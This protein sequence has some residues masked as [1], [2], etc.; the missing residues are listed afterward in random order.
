MTTGQ[1]SQG[2]ASCVE[3][4]TSFFS[5]LAYPKI[6]CSLQ[7]N[8]YES[9]FPSSFPLLAWCCSC[10]GH[11]LCSLVRFFEKCLWMISCYTC[12]SDCWFCCLLP[13]G[14]WHDGRPGLRPPVIPANHQPQYISALFQH[15]RTV[16]ASVVILDKIL[17]RLIIIII[18]ISF[19]YQK[20]K[21]KEPLI[22]WDNIFF[23]NWNHVSDLEISVF[24]FTFQAK[25]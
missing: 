24:S 7:S 17:L 14:L 5:Q 9:L 23:K 4:L 16:A 2:G 20:Y 11:S 25:K 10:F 18:H 3:E 19:H 1:T 22:T 21:S 12:T 13:A 15:Q 8:P 6:F